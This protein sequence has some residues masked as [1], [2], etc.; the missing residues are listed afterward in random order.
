MDD[1]PPA[2]V[3]TH[4]EKHDGKLI[5]RG[6]CSDNGPVKKV[7]VNGVEAKATAT[8]FAE[9]EATLPGD[10]TKVTAHAEDAAGNVEKTPHVVT[11][12]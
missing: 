11:V 2:T 5:V 9:W 6:T 1:L 7:V 3:I 12:R 10:T 4:V 8:N